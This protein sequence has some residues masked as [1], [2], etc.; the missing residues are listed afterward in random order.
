MYAPTNVDNTKKLMAKHNRSRVANASKKTLAYKAKPYNEFATKFQPKAQANESTCSSSAEGSIGEPSPQTTKQMCKTL[1]QLNTTF[2]QQHKQPSTMVSCN[3]SS[4]GEEE[5]EVSNERKFK[6]CVIIDSPKEGS[7]TFDLEG[8]DRHSNEDAQTVSGTTADNQ[9]SK[10]A[11]NND[12]CDSTSEN[13]KTV[14]S[15]FHFEG[16]STVCG[17]R[18]PSFALTGV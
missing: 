14:K 6:S 16:E 11:F 5:F 1:P 3:S 9:S 4:C 12:L 17:S 10:F 13:G 2:H 18:R 7:S 8:G 15:S